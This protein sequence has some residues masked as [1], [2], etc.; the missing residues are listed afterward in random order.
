MT[1]LVFEIPPRDLSDKTRRVRGMHPARGNKKTNKQHYLFCH[2]PLYSR[3][4]KGSYREQQQ[5]VIVRNRFNYE[6]ND[7]LSG[8]ASYSGQRHL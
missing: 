4:C 1:C 3:E 5:T 2:W 8:K 6:Q 7:H